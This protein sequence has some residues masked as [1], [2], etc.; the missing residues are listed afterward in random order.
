[1]L[2]N[3]AASERA[4]ADALWRR[5]GWVF[6]P[7]SILCILNAIFQST[8]YPYFFYTLYWTIP[9]IVWI[10]QVPLMI[11]FI[12][13]AIVVWRREVFD[14]TSIWWNLTN[15]FFFLYSLL[16]AIIL[17][18]PRQKS[19]A[20]F[21]AISGFLTAFPM[22]VYL[23]MIW[24][25]MWKKR[26]DPEYLPSRAFLIT[27]TIAGFFFILFVGFIYHPDVFTLIF[28]H[29]GIF[30]GHIFFE[31]VA[32]I[33]LFFIPFF[34]LARYL[35]SPPYAK[36]PLGTT[37]A[38]PVEPLSG[39]VLAYWYGWP[40]LF[41]AISH[42]FAISIPPV[43]CTNAFSEWTSD[44]C[45][46][47]SIL[48][49]WDFICG[50]L[51]IPVPVKMLIH[52]RPSMRRLRSMAAPAGGN[53]TGDV[54]KR[55]SSLVPE[56]AGI[57][58]EPAGSAWTSTQDHTSHSQLPPLA[59]QRCC[60]LGCCC[61]WGWI[62]AGVILLPILILV[63]VVGAFPFTYYMPQGATGPS[64]DWMMNRTIIPGIDLDASLD[65]CEDS[66]GPPFSS[67]FLYVLRDQVY[68]VTQAQRVARLFE[69]YITSPKAA[70]FFDQWVGLWAM[71]DL[72]KLSTPATR[73]IF[74]GPWNYTLTASRKMGGL[75]QMIAEDSKIWL[76]DG[77]ALVKLFARNA[78]VAPGN[79]LYRQG[80]T[81][82]RFSFEP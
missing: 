66:L 49:S 5:A 31:F 1:M 43:H 28:F 18:I 44:I 46:P 21:F 3:T 9:G 50:L 60:R 53:H 70:G 22:L 52:Y 26:R 57:V 17:W 72:Y 77:D 39:A 16:F 41:Y 74:E 11:S 37:A 24:Y 64:A 58:P 63:I 15:T 12:G 20:A 33:I 8:I 59:R 56:T 73:P 45:V 23:V 38:P 36:A 6:I 68:N 65:I 14:F 48:A 25:Y 76:G 47:S 55:A 29:F 4:Y 75:S 51:L 13:M 35:K 27:A 19:S 81:L 10:F 34:H 40:L 82:P 54:E 2:D 32:E 62:V 80:K 79:W 30:S 42:I 71:V 7:I 69:N 61:F 78:I 67:L